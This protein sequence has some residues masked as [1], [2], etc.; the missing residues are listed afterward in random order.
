MTAITAKLSALPWQDIL[1][2]L[3]AALFFIGG[4]LIFL[5]NVYKGLSTGV[6]RA[7]Y[8]NMSGLYRRDTQPMFFWLVI[9][10]HTCLVLG[11][12]G[13]GVFLA[14]QLCINH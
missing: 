13:L 4:P 11:I 10:L 8:L 9:F 3:G 6:V 12:S 14:V 2:C 7:Q 5:V 1:I